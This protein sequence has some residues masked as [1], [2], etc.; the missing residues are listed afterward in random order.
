MINFS[1]IQVSATKCGLL[2]ISPEAAIL[3]EVSYCDF[4]GVPFDQSEREQIAR[5]LGP[6]NKVHCF[7]FIVL[8]I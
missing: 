8:F 4:H 6:V 2:P 3:G 5:S 7:A 1:Q